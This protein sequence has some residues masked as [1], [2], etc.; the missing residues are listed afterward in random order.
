[1]RILSS[2]YVAR[3]NAI[4]VIICVMQVH[5]AGLVNTMYMPPGA[6]VVEAIPFDFIDSR[7]IPTIGIF[8]RLAA[9]FGLHHYT[10][11]SPMP[12]WQMHDMAQEAKAFQDKCRRKA[13]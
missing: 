7:H 6:V 9:T 8:A 2:G 12:T 4:D 3:G 11:V 13:E 1:M 5:G 10:Y